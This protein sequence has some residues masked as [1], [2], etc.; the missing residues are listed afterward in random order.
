MCPWEQS[1]VSLKNST[2]SSSTMSSTVA[3]SSGRGMSTVVSLTAGAALTEKT[4]ALPL[5]TSVLGAM[6]CSTTVPA[7]WSLATSF[8]STTRP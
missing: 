2:P 1:T 3:R 8:S 7:G 6:L 5:G 4:M